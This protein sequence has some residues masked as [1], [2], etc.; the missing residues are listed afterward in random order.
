MVE[1]PFDDG[2]FDVVTASLSLHHLALASDR[3]SAMRE[4]MRVTRPGGAL[5]ILDVAKTFEYGA[6]LDDAGWIDVVRERAHYGHYPPVRFVTATKPATVKRPR[7]AQRAIRSR[8][9]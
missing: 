8:G 5:V 7:A 4:L 2:E 9:R 6:W 3:G 1:L